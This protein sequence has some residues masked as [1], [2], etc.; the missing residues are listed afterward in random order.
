MQSPIV[1]N[2][3]NI[4][5]SRYFLAH[6]TGTCWHCR[7]RTEFF[8]L[9]VPPGHETREPDDEP[10]DWAGDAAQNETQ[11]EAQNETQNEALA[12]DTW[13]VATH[14]AFLFYIEFL[15][16]VIQDRLKQFT[17]SYRLEFSDAAQGP[18]WANH[19]ERCGSL[20]DDHELFCEPEGAFLPTSESS[21][22]AIHL[23]ALDEAFEAAAGGYA[24]EPQFFNAM[25]RT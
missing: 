3:V 15:P 4:R 20:L 5:S 23:L 12:V 1:R 16:A 10:P 24:H 2:D 17:Q 22:G 8:A 6:T 18:Y 25:S 13:C 19:C 21:A 9:V 11:D 14:H 7:A